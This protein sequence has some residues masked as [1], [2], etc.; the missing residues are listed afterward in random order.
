MNKN[1][2]NNIFLTLLN[3]LEIYPN[4]LSVNLLFRLKEN[5]SV[6]PRSLWKKIYILR[7][8]STKNSFNL[9]YSICSVR[10]SVLIRSPY[11]LFHVIKETGMWGVGVGCL[12]CEIIIK[13][14]L[15]RRICG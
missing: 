4:K 3:F 2:F 5:V 1:N 13:S 14:K 11:L 7:Y 15:V 9:C 6:T 8:H 10:F 12:Y